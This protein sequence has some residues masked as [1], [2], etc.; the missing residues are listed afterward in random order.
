LPRLGDASA[1]NRATLENATYG[2]SGL[3]T[4]LDKII[5][6]IIKGSGTELPSNKSLYDVIGLDRLDSATYGLAALKTLLDTLVTRLE[7]RPPT[8]YNAL[9]DQVNPVQNTW[10]TVLDTVVNAILFDCFAQVDTTGETIAVRITVDGNALTGS[11]AATGSSTYMTRLT[12]GILAGLD[13]FVPRIDLVH[14]WLLMG[15]SVK[16]EVRKTTANGT[17]DLRGK[18]NYGIWT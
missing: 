6:G 3:N 15:R 7:S 13:L 9:L 2:L 8:Y 11:V 14:G 10:Y 17:G 18:V 4:D 16:V 5:T 12:L 1:R